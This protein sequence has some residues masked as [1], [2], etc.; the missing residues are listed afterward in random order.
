MTRRQFGGAALAQTAESLLFPDIRGIEPDLIVPPLTMGTPSPGA[1]VK[2]HREGFHGE[3]VYHVIYL[4]RNWKPRRR[5]PLIV[6]Y[7][8]NGN[9]RNQYGDVSTGV[10]EGSSLGYG[11][12]GGEEFIW[13]CLPY[14]DAR[15]GRNAITW[16]GNPEATIDYCL[17]AVKETVSR[18]GADPKRVLLCGFSRGALACNYL[19]LRDDR[20]A[21]LWR[22]F[23]CYSHYDGVRT[24]PQY[25]DCDRA[26]ALKRLRRL[27]GRPQFIC[28]ERSVEETRAYLASTGVRGDF[29]LRDLPFRNHNDAWVLR[30][31]PLRVELRAW[32]KRAILD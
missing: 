31:V 8:G 13:L 17:G 25:A 1:R 9:Y 2:A 12:S 29:T 21:R 19:G 6:E 4:P 28:H 26:S 5:Y 22:G 7:A 24:W 10:P 23:F 20:I 16:W 30:P 32:V 3:G 27:G 18:Y 14:V 11:V 15:A